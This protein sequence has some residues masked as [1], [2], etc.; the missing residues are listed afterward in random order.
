MDVLD[1]KYELKELRMN[2]YDMFWSGRQRWR[3][4]LNSVSVY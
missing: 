2:V 1:I 3:K 4:F